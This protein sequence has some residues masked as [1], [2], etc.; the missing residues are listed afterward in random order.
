VD[1]SCETKPIYPGIGFQGSGISQLTPDPRPLT[2]GA[3]RPIVRNEPN[4][5]TCR[6]GTPNLP[7]ANYAKQSQT[8]AGWDIWGTAHPE[9]PIMQNEANFQIADCGPRSQPGLTILWIGD[10]PAAGRPLRPVASGLRGPVVQTN[11][12]GWRQSCETNPIWRAYRARQSQLPPGRSRAGT[13]NPRR[14]DYAKRSQFGGRDMRNEP[15]FGR[16]GRREPPS[17][18][19]SIIPPF[20]SN[21]DCA[22][23]TQFPAGPGGTGPQGRGTWVKCAKQTQFG[24]LCRAA[25]P[26][27]S[28]LRP[29]PWAG[30][31]C[32]K[33]TQFR[34]EPGGPGLGG[35][36]TNVQNEANLRRARY[37]IIPVFYRSTI[38]SR[39]RLLDAT[40]KHR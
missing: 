2:P 24:R 14:V 34:A 17:F 27:P 1:T 4:L 38:P 20:R 40:P 22:K 37:P 16:G 9:R 25:F 36:G 32:A 11:P 5:E 28:T 39:C 7:R 18:Q 33:R 30:G 35:Q 21:A 31:G 19:Y 10:R 26:R 15:N 13:P 12:I 23:R 3:P 6:A 29:R 8:W